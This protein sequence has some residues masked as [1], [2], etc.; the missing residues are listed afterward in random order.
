MSASPG[1]HLDAARPTHPRVLH[2]DHTTV[3]GGAEFALLRMLQAGAP[4]SPYVMIAPTEEQGLGVYAGLPDD[5]PRR[6][7]GVRQP[8]GV[9]WG[10]FGL[11]V[12]AGVRLVAQ[13][14]AT[15]MH[16]A[17]RRADLVDANTARAAA[18]GALAA[19]LSRVPFVVHV[20]DMTDADALGR[21]GRFLMTRV[22][23]P[24]AD[25]I[26][27]DT[28]PPLDSARPYLRPRCA[29]ERDP[30]RIGHPTPP[31]AAAQ[32]ARRRARGHAGAHRPVEGPASCSSTPS[33]RR[34]PERMPA[35]SSRARRRSGTTTSSPSC[36]SAPRSSA[37]PTRSSSTGTCP[38]STP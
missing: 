2:L 30:E 8:A 21:T 16:R 27:S 31:G 12:V 37:S 20:R 15:R 9:S 26:I 19:R 22:I 29:R 6:F 35:W 1:Q 18:Y 28:H 4:W 3:A 17:F 25:G 11:Q 7:I 10:G 38:M 13:A 33:P 14:F 36:T 5:V 24:R 23:L 34:S 32:G